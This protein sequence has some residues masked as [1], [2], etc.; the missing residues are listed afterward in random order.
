MRGGSA[1]ATTLKKRNTKGKCFSCGK[2]GHFKGECTAPKRSGGLC[3]GFGTSETDSYFVGIKIRGDDTLQCAACAAGRPTR[4]P[5]MVK[6][7]RLFKNGQAL[8]TIDNVGPMQTTSHD[9]YTGMVSIII[10]PYHLASVFPVK[11]KSAVA[12][13][14]ALKECI[15]N[16]RPV[17]LGSQE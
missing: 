9:G 7:P 16:L 2:R 12:Q 15:A 10:E 5:F 4:S 17:L 6:K 8:I 14:R 3:N 11:A 13:L 1:F